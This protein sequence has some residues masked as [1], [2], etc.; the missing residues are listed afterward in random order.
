MQK[1]G[2]RKEVAM[3]DELPISGTGRRHTNTCWTFL[4]SMAGQVGVLALMLVI[5]MIYVQALPFEWRLMSLIPPPP[6]SA[7]PPVARAAERTPPPVRNRITVPPVIPPHAR[8]IH[9]YAPAPPGEGPKILEIP[10]AIPGLGNDNRL[11]AITSSGTPRPPAPTSRPAPLRVG[12]DLQE[13]KLVHMV[14]PKYPEAARKS[15]VQGTVV[16][17][18]KIAED[19]SVVELR[20]ISG[21]PLLVPA[22]QKAVSQ[23]RYRP[24]LLNGR[25]V[26]IQ[27]TI[28]V[29]FFLTPNKRGKAPTKP[30]SEPYPFGE[31]Y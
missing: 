7:P 30:V 3:F 5:P 12:G 15:Y 2:S 14:R 23:W 17:E 10:G 22:V 4:V 29:I 21:P 24:T 27:T 13:A 8:I 31:S 1:A 6:P 19:G 28:T 16:L 11:A 26:A 18:A 25:P 9:D 20:Y